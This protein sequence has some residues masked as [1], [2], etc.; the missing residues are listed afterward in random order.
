MPRD[1]LV[2]CNQQ[3]LRVEIDIGHAGPEG[4]WVVRSLGRWQLW[5][6]DPKAGL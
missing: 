2:S 6:P 1:G 4:Y 3:I 5:I